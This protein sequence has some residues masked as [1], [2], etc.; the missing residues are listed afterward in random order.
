MTKGNPWIRDNKNT[1]PEGRVKTLQS[2]IITHSCRSAII[3]ILIP[4]VPC[5]HP[6]LFA[7]ASYGAQNTWLQILFTTQHELPVT[8]KDPAQALGKIILQC[9]HLGIC[10]DRLGIR[11]RGLTGIELHKMIGDLGD[12]HLLTHFN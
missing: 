3:S 9:L 4:R 10:G 11:C 6:W 2:V 5:S 8:R 12:I 7:Y 1:A